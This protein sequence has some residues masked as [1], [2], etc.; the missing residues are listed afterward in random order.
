VRY[1]HTHAG[2]KGS[3]GGGLVTGS[4]G[5]ERGGKMGRGRGRGG[6]GRGGRGGGVRGGA[7]VR[8]WAG[9]QACRIGCKVIVYWD[10]DEAWFS[11]LVVGHST[12]NGY[13]CVCVFACVCVCLCVCVCMR[14]KTI[15]KTNE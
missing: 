8:E 4:S 5:I 3:Q 12:V 9:E 7:G 2:T 6:R 15:V 11:G 1:T 13:R 14:E 10:G